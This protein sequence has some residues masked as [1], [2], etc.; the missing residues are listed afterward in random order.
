MPAIREFPFDLDIEVPDDPY[1]WMAVKIYQQ[2]WREVRSSNGNREPARLWLEGCAAYWL[3]A[4]VFGKGATLFRNW[5]LAGCPDQDKARQP[6]MKALIKREVS[7][8][9]LDY[10]QLGSSKVQVVDCKECEISPTMKFL[11][12]KKVYL[13]CQR[14]GKK[15]GSHFFV[16]EAADEWEDI[17]E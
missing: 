7:Q 14:C 4:L 5:A 13:I 11:H 9:P 8:M 17:N 12:S 10:E 15:T 2:A 1:V 6:G 16:M 3:A